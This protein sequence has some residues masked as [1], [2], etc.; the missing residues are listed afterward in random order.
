MSR[1]R[2]LERQIRDLIN[3]PRKRTAIRKNEEHWKRL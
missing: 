3:E 1:I 2:E